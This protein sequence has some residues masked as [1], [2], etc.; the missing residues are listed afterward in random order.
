[1]INLTINTEPSLMNIINRFFDGHF[2]MDASAFSA[3]VHSEKNYDLIFLFVVFIRKFSFF[4]EDQ[5]EY[6]E[7]NNSESLSGEEEELKG[8][9]EVDVDDDVDKAVSS[10]CN[11]F[12]S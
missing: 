9:I 11:T 2:G 6:Y 1:M 10:E 7:K 3:T 5:I 4:T 8:K 12:R